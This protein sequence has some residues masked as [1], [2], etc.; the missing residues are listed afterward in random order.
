MIHY[1]A[2]WLGVSPR[3]LLQLSGSVA[4]KGLFWAIPA[5]GIAFGLFHYWDLGEGGEEESLGDLGTNTTGDASEAPKGD[6]RSTVIK[7]WTGYSF[8]LGF[9]IVFRMQQAYTR[10]WEAATLTNELRAEWIDAVQSCVAFC[11]EKPELAQEVE[12]YQHYIIRLVSML[13]RAALERLSPKGD[14]EEFLLFDLKNI[15]KIS[16]LSEVTDRCEC[17]FQWIMK[18]IVKANKAGII[19]IPPPILGRTFA[20]MSTGMAKLHNV[21]KIGSI[22]IPFPYVQMSSFLLLFHWFLTPIVGSLIMPTARWAACLS[23]MSIFCLWSIYYISQ[24]IEQPFG[25]HKNSLPCAEMQLDCNRILSLLVCKKVQEPPPYHFKEKD[26]NC[27]I[28]KGKTAE[29][30]ERKVLGSISRK[31]LHADD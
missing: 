2:G 9:L 15:D 20:E 22:P 29:A 17:I 28:M 6:G 12:K 25:A 11:T 19:E 7:V 1:E 3:L 8:V 27:T 4:P 13:H 23:F 16:Y 21:M 5:A 26:R 18:S 14:E 24:E 10:F 31:T 30:S